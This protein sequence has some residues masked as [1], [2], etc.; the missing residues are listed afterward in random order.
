MP[1][2]TRD[3][4][5]RSGSFRLRVL[6]PI[7][8]I[9]PLAAFGGTGV[10]TAIPYAL[11]CIAALVVSRPGIAAPIDRALMVLA[12]G[13][14]LQT[15]PMPAALVGVL[16]PHRAEVMNALTIG[17]PVPAALQPLSIDGR[18]TWWALAVFSGAAALFWIA[19]EQFGHHGV[20]RTVR[21]IAGVGLAV[22]LLAL[23]QLATAGRSVYWRFPTEVEG[24]LPFGPFVNRNHFATWI[25][26]ALPLC[27]GYLVAR[28]GARH[29]RPRHVAVRTRLA[30]SMDAR[31]IWLTTAAVVMSA[32]L[33]VSLSRSGVLALAIAGTATLLASKQRIDERRRRSVLATIAVVGLLGLLWADIPALK[34]RISGA[35]GAVADRATIWRETLPVVRDFWVAGTGAGTYQR[36]MYVYQRSDRT[37]FFNQAHNH[38]LQ[39]AAEGGGLLF[40]CLGYGLLAL[41]RAARERIRA[42]TSGLVWIRIGAACGLAAVGLQSFWET[43]LVMPANAAIAAVLV[44]IVVHP[45]KP[46]ASAGHN[47]VS[48]EER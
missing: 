22:S 39:V 32:A 37:V 46:L 8:L 29:G 1:S 34:G 28:T 15:L 21:L 42:D 5:D 33:L 23:A 19:R 3:V 12:A 36:A 44:A 30:H 35:R 4:R 48:V 9:W 20:R 11:T 24:P 47:P 17:P 7:L 41:A 40:G 26:M 2:A 45:S 27:V 16:S 13:I 10:S 25:I 18:A 38:Y 43:G 14:L 31:N 6:L